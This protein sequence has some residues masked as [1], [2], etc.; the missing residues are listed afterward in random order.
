MKFSL[1]IPV[2]PGR[3]AEILESIKDLDFSKKQF[4]VIVKPGKNASENRNNGSR[5]ARGEFLVFLDDDAFIDKNY[6]NNLNEFLRKNQNVEII[7]G[8]QLTPEEDKFFAKISGIALSSWFGGFKVN[9][10]YESKKEK[11]GVNETAVTSA[12]LVVKK[13]S[14]EKIGGFNLDLFRGQ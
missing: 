5:E 4:E 12:N 2:A 8:P 11:I 9:Q 14:F 10:R 3:N 1:I 6:L 13:S 7:G